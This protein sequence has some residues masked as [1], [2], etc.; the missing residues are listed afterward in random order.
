M[1]R[2]DKL[3]VMTIRS[4]IGAIDNAGAVQAEVDWHDPKIGVG[5]DVDRRHVSDEEEREILMAERDDLTAAAAQ[6]RDLDQ[7][8]RADEMATRAAIVAEFL[9]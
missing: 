1:K 6:Y 3:R 2:R 4:L 5:H 8:D 9:D 7:A